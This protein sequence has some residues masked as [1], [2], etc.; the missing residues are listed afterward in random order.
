MLN[1]FVGAIVVAVSM[2][3]LMRACG[4][5]NDIEEREFRDDVYWVNGLKSF[6]DF[7]SQ[8]Q[9]LRGGRFRCVE[10][11]T[12][13]RVAVWSIVICGLYDSVEVGK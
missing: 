2:L 12:W 10:N 6:T 11:L 9:S 1:L 7:S 8:K 5:W 3:S 13:Q 4:V